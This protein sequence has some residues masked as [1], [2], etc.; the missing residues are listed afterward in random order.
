MTKGNIQIVPGSNATFS[1]GSNSITINNY[2][3]Q[4][5]SFR[6]IKKGVIREI[7]I[8]NTSALLTDIH[9]TEKEREKASNY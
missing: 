2:G 6:L 9:A 8:T 7:I 3:P 5:T 4:K 1:T